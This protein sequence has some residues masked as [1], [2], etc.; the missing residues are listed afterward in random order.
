MRTCT[1]SLP[2]FLAAPSNFLSLPS[3][4]FLKNK[5]LWT[6]TVHPRLLASCWPRRGWSLT[7]LTWEELPANGRTC[8]PGGGGASCSSVS[9]RFI[10][11]YA[12]P[13]TESVGIPLSMPP[14]VPQALAVLPQIIRHDW[15]HG[16][17]HWPAT[18][19]PCSCFN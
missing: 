16:H 6:L 8:L 5:F 3:T 10:G 17:L 19:F 12:D 2:T 13:P 14:A 18:D 1:H 9:S 15:N 7:D 11:S 4:Q